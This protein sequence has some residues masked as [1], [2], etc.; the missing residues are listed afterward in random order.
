MNDKGEVRGVRCVKLKWSLGPDGRFTPSEVPDSAFEI[1]CQRVLLAMGFMHPAAATLKSFGVETDA[2]GNAKAL[3]RKAYKVEQGD[4]KSVLGR[5]VK[6]GP[7]P[8]VVVVDPPRAGIRCQGR[9]VSCRGARC[10]LYTF[11]Q[12]ATLAATQVP[13]YLSQ[14]KSRAYPR[15]LAEN[16]ILLTADTVVILNGEVLGKPEDREDAIRMLERLSGHRH[17]VVTGVTLRTAR[18][19]RSFSVRSNVWF[20]A[21]TREEIVYYV[22]NFHP[23][24]RPAATAFRSGSAMPPSSASTARSSTS[25]GCRSNASIPNSINSF[26]Q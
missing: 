1:P 18:R 6:L 7:K 9:A 5:L 17:T 23:L 2:R 24:D 26:N 11:V 21:L 13:R 12:P 4:A 10:G 16:E 20:R 8:D 3:G 15:P 22:D 14:L 19:R 25:W